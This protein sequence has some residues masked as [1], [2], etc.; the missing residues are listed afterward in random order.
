MFFKYRPPPQFSTARRLQR[1]PPKIAQPRAIEPAELLPRR[2]DL[3]IAIYAVANAPARRP[4][5]DGL[6]GLT[7]AP[8]VG[9]DDAEAKARQLRVRRRLVREL[10][11]PMLSRMACQMR[12]KHGDAAR[13]VG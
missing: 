2:L 6:V 4:L 10:G 12:P 1:R 11:E 3:R 5:V 13:E 7:R 9:P 8:V